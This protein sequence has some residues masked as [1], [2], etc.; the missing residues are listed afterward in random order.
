[1]IFWPQL[2]NYIEPDLKGFLLKEKREESLKL[3][4]KKSIHPLTPRTSTSL[5][6]VIQKAIQ[7]IGDNDLWQNALLTCSVRSH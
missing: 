6:K 5:L 4:K 3:Q 7:F 2:R 1:M